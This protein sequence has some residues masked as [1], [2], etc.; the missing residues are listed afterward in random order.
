MFS[1]DLFLG[2]IICFFS[3]F[4]YERILCC[5]NGKKYNDLFFSLL[6]VVMTILLLIY[7]KSDLLLV[8]LDIPII[9][10]YLKNDIKDAIVLSILIAILLISFT[11]ISPIILFL[12]FITYFASYL[13]FREYR[14]YIINIL[15][16]V[17]AF[18]ISFIYFKY[19]VNNIP[20][21]F[22]YL[23]ATIIFL[24]LV[25]N[26]LMLLLGSKNN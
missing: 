10:S 1:Y 24:N 4:V 14:K 7:S 9:L 20:L 11:S 18:F 25:I 22:L 15:F 26:L 13:I 21:S 5:F 23:F 2:A 8:F 17:K 16:V 3:F 12:L 19:Y 6:L